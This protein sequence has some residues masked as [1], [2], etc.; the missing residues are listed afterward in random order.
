MKELVIISGKGGTGKTTVTAAFASLA[1]HKVMADCDVDAADL[2]LILNPEIIQQD[3]F[4]GGKTAY[5]RVDDCIECGKC[6]EVCQFNAIN[7]DY[8]V[9]LG[10]GAGDAGGLVIATGTPEEIAQKG[11]S[12]TG[13]YLQSILKEH[14]KEYSLP[15]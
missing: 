9:D 5:I 14:Y 8:I 4:Y 13:K 11:S 15:S 2:H 3:D 1:Q 12:F 6:L 7:A 10:P